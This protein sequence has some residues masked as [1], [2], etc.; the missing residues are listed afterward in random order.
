VLQVA[1]DTGAGVVVDPDQLTAAVAWHYPRAARSAAGLGTLVGW[2]WREAGW[3]GLVGLGATSSYALALLA[4]D[5]PLPAHLADLFPAPVDKIV[6]Q[7]DL[8][9]VAPGP[10]PHGL[11]G[12]LRLLAD[13]ESRGGG[14][15]YRFSA[16]SVRRA[17]EAGWSAVEVHAWLE[18][19]SATGVPQPLA[20]LVD[21]MARQYGSIRV[22]SAQS[23]IR[24]QDPAQAAALLASPDARGLGLRTLAAGVL[25]SSAEASDLVAFLRAAGHA[26]AV[27][28]D[29]G[30]TLST[31]PSQRAP[32]P[33]PALAPQPVPP[34]EAAQAIAA[35][36]S[37]LPAPRTEA[38]HPKGGR[39]STTEETLAEL[40]NATL[41]ATA[42]RVRF[43][44]TE[45]EPLERDLHP[46]DVTAGTMRAMDAEDSRVLTIPLARIS[47][48]LAVPEAN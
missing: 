23:Y 15:V 20:Y 17:F 7:A 25:V 47:S 1:V 18:E 24:V 39:G 42:V 36:E 16:G 31:P 34:A 11:A 14:G 5:E 41:S 21:D 8:T 40:H 27:E 3:L 10:L 35:V 44:T 43:V 12:D 30:S 22:G 4:Q 45:G 19:H 6:V 37:R 9:A 2:A 29:T 33:R 28:D 32:S 46:L 48:A 38:L 13:Q 26:P